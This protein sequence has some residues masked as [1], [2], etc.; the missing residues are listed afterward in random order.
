MK[1]IQPMA[2]AI[3]ATVRSRKRLVMEQ[4]AERLVVA[5][6][7]EAARA[8]LAVAP[9]VVERRAALVAAQRVAAAARAAAEVADELERYLRGE[10]VVARPVPA[11][12][13]A[14]KPSTEKQELDRFLG[15]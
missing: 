3:L 11:P 7:A 14:A 15:R 9:P 8:V 6:W 1:K 12:A 2:T 13:P 5:A 4:A 10:P